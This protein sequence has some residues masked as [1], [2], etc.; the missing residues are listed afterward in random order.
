MAAQGICRQDPKGLLEIH[1]PCT[2]RMSA[3]SKGPVESS[4]KAAKRAARQMC[5]PVMACELS[6]ICE[7]PV[8]R[9]GEVDAGATVLR[10]YYVDSPPPLTVGLFFIHNHADGT[11]SGAHCTPFEGANTALAHLP[12]GKARQFAQVAKP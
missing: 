6:S 3:G 11:Y 2:T 7:E 5:R 4:C 9:A 10:F 8:K 12:G 1:E